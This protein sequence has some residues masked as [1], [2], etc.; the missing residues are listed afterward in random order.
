LPESTTATSLRELAA[1][2]LEAFEQRQEERARAESA[3][4]QE[5]MAEVGLRAGRYARQL[6]GPA[7]EGARWVALDE[8]H[9]EA[10]IDGE[11][12]RFHG[13]FRR[14]YDLSHVTACPT[15]GRPAQ[16][17]IASLADLGELLRDKP[18]DQYQCGH[19]DAE[20]VAKYEADRQAR[21]KAD[22]AALDEL[23]PVPDY[24]V[25]LRTAVKLTHRARAEYDQHA[26]TA[27][28][29][30]AAVSQALTGLAREI[31]EGE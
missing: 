6:L 5:E 24:E 17:V 8:H 12:F 21:L 7:A 2:A 30:S 23:P 19:C 28:I 22:Q 13:P 10:V 29:A 18:A 9:A 31:R 26:Y 4:R 1:A 16:A 3:R 25:T 15:C 27:A 14:P 20:V 11:R